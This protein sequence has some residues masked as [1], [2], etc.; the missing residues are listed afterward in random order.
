MVALTDDF[1][2]ADGPIGAAWTNRGDT[3][4]GVIVGNQATTSSTASTDAV[5][6]T[7]VT[8]ATTAAMVSQAVFTFTSLT[9]VNA[10][11]EL[12]NDMTVQGMTMGMYDGTNLFIRDYT[13]VGTTRITKAFSLAI[14]TPHT[15]RFEMSAA[16]VADLYVNGAKELTFNYGSARTLRGVGFGLRGTTKVNNWFGGDLASFPALPMPAPM[17]TR[18]AAR[19]AMGL[20]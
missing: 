9:N 11:I 13:G 10:I 17:D 3:A 20:R 14:N 4:T 6:V 8:P 1:D 7:N 2:R 19:S 5:H 18:H 16:G 15:F 12:A